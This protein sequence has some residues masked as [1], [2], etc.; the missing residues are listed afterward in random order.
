MKFPTAVLSFI[1]GPIRTETKDDRKILTHL[2]KYSHFGFMVTWPFCFHFWLFWKLQKKDPWGEF[3]HPGTEQGI[4]FRT[5]GWR[6]DIDLGM[7]WTWGYAGLH[8]D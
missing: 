3:W 1:T 6:W 4:Y 5:C 2:Q 8:W 7:K